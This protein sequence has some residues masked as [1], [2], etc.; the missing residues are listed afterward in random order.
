MSTMQT[1]I[2]RAASDPEFA[3][4]LARDARGTLRA[5]GLSV[6]EEELATLTAGGRGRAE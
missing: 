2:A 6:T 5:A 4:G 3:Q 1:I